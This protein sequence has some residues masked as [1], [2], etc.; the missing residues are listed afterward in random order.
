[1]YNSGNNFLN[2]HSVMVRVNCQRTE[3]I[4]WVIGDSK[5]C[6]WGLFLLI[7]VRRAFPASKRRVEKL[8]VLRS[9]LIMDMLWYESCISPSAPASAALPLP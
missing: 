8:C 6:L 4:I 2:K 5:E 7:D 1:M 3:Y 9:L